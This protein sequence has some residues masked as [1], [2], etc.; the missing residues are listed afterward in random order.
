MANPERPQGGLGERDIAPDPFT[1]FARWFHD[2]ASVPDANAMTLATATRDGKV[3]ARVVLLKGFDER[4][5]SFFTNYE[6]RKGRELAEN[7][8]AALVFYWQP[9]GRQVRIEGMVTRISEEE[10]DA[11]FRTRPVGSQLGALA[12]PQSQPIPNREFLET[13]Y[14]ELAERFTLDPVPRP[15]HWGGYRLAPHA[16]EFW[17]SRDNRLHDRILYTRAGPDTWRVVRLAP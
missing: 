4:G 9:L 8:R 15:K 3:S 10:S 2:A 16:V 6:S 1:Q 13:R 14:N 7:P 5:F 12:S 17:Q 11:Y